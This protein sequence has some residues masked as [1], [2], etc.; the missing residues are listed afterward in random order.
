MHVLDL[1]SKFRP[2]LCNGQ[3]EE[4]LVRVITKLTILCSIDCIVRS[5]VTVKKCSCCRVLLACVKN[6]KEF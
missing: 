3:E 1:A 5:A 2:Q 4:V 6:V